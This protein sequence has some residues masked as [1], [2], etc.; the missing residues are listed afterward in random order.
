[1]LRECLAE[2]LA[3]RGGLVLI[4]GEAG[5]GKTAL[6]EAT[7]REAAER[8]ALVL[9]GR[10]YD[11]TET[12][13]YGPWTEL[14]EQLP[15]APD[16]PPPPA[17]A[18]PGGAMGGAG[19]QAA[20]FAQ[21]RDFLAALAGRRPL[22]L[23]LD[24]LHWADPASLDL[25]RF[26]ARQVGGLPVLLLV[27]YRDDELTRRHPLYHLLPAL[28]REAHARRLDVRPLDEEAVLA[29]ARARYRLAEV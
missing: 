19:S 3:G 24:D 11:G 10:C 6:A 26:L 16:L 18:A 15:P 5:I 21:V 4:G 29:L 23:L 25:L 1:M 17:I 14:L 20:L 12:P 7:G 13:P 27:T 22:A 9:I 2:A 28:V 8:G